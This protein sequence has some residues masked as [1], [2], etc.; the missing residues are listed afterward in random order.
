[1]SLFFRVTMACLITA[2]SRGFMSTPP[3]RY[4]HRLHLA[5]KL[6]DIS[7]GGGIAGIVILLVNRLSSMDSVTDIQVRRSSVTWVLSNLA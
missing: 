7:I 2:V 5:P 6:S 3:P 4:H 1:M